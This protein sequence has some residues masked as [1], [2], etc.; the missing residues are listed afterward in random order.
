VLRGIFASEKRKIQQD[1]DNYIA[2]GF[3]ICSLRQTLEGHQP[4]MLKRL[5]MEH[6]K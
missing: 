6:T 1:G 3:I 5:D 2:R 4:S